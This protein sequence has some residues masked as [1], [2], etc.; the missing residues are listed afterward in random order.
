MKNLFVLT[1][2]CITLLFLSSCSKKVDSDVAST[3]VT[4]QVS[5]IATSADTSTVAP[6]QGPSMSPTPSASEITSPLNIVSNNTI[7]YSNPI[8]EYFVPRI[9]D[10]TKCEAEKRVYQDTYRDVWEA[11]YENIMKYMYSKC[12][13][14]VD[15]KNLATY[16]KNVEK[17]IDSTRTVM[18]TD[19]S[20]TYKTPTDKRYPGRIGGNGTRSAL[21]QIEAEIYRDAGMRLIDD[22]YIFLKKD[23]SKEHYE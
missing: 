21:N 3:Q 8:D 13:Y 7:I 19:W 15:K 11:E 16:N 22:T 2:Y 10:K 18:V 9:N 23:Y 20:D 12:V 4:P 1:I 5:T 14:Q 6:S 17:L